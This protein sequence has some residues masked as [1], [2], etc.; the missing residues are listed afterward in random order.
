VCLIRPPGVCRVGSDTTFLIEVLRLG[1]YAA[2]RRVLDVGTGTGALALAA[3]R[4]GAASV[5]AVDLSL[6]SVAAAWLNSRLHRVM[7]TVRWGDLCGPVADQQFD[8]ILANPPYVPAATEALSRHRINRC[9]DGGLDGRVVVDRLCTEGPDLLAP[10]GMMLVVHSA[11]CDEDITLKRFADT[12][13]QAEVI[14]RC[15]VP[16]G[17]VMRARA[18]M[19]ASRGLVE[20]GQ[21]DEELVVIGAQRGR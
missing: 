18:A 6:R 10:G 1:G 13:L 17:P 16:F 21:R 11:V 14:A 12:G 15:T 7:C 5:T 19:L 9:W 8:L 2:G 4:A 20:P 3:A